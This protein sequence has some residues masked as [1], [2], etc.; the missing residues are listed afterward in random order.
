MNKSILILDDDRNFSAAVSDYLTTRGYLVDTALDAQV[1]L[2][3]LHHSHYDLCLMDITM[4]EMSGLDVLAQLR[5]EQYPIAIIM[6]T[7][8]SAHEDMLTAYHLGCDDYLVKPYPLDLLVC[9]IEAV[10]RRTLPSEQEQTS[11]D[12]GGGITFDAIH[13][14]LGDVEIRS[15][16]S[17]L[18]L[19]LCQ[20]RD[21]LV[22]RSHLLKHVWGQDTYFTG[23]S[24]SVYINHLRNHLQESGCSARILAIHGKGY[25]LV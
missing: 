8:R 5:D 2:D 22:S 16:E 18:L 24:M 14:R 3:K 19:M 21:Q 20:N 4:P 7:G 23:R 15:K 1:G 9:R 25:K 17:E 11:F 12:L 10:L 6:L 13:Q